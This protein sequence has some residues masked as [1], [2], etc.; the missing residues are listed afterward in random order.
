MV[1]Q[2]IS[3]SISPE[4]HRRLE[5]YRDS[6]NISEICRGALT[7]KLDE[8]ESR[9]KGKKQMTLVARLQ[10]EKRVVTDDAYKLGQKQLDAD[11]EHLSYVDIQRL[12]GQPFTMKG[13][14]LYLTVER[15]AP[16]TR[17]ARIPALPLP[18]LPGEKSKEYTQQCSS[19][20]SLPNEVSE[21]SFV[22]G[23]LD[24]LKE[25]WETELKAQVEG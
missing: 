8:I 19:W 18:G 1:R 16:K 6:I 17:T 2:Q 14:E 11:L 22:K 21:R 23:Y 9:R 13:R 20:P 24:R 5:E 4:L 7:E 10:K 3:I 15:M 12:L 25:R